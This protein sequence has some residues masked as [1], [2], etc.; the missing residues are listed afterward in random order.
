[1]MVIMF[2]IVTIISMVMLVL[3]GVTVVSMV[4]LMLAGM[5]VLTVVVVV[6]SLLLGAVLGRG[7]RLAGHQNRSGEEQQQHA[8]CQ[9]DAES[10]K[11]NVH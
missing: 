4:V 7:A 6:L 9:R 11:V 1:M 8:G 3:I 2:I 10:T 5:A